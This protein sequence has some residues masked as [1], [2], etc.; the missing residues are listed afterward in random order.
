MANSSLHRNQAGTSF[1]ACIEA[2][3]A[4]EIVIVYNENT[5]LYITMSVALSLVT[6][7]GNLL[8]LV[9][10]QSVSSIHPPSKA[11]FQCL[12]ITDLGVGLICQPLFISYLWA[13]EERNWSFCR[14]MEGLAITAS[15]VFCGQ[16]I[17]TLTAL[18]VDRLLALQLRLR[19]RH[20]VTLSRVRIF[21]AAFWVTN[22]AFPFTFYGSK[23]FYFSWCFGWVFMCLTLSTCCY[24]KIYLVLGQRQP[25]IL[26][27]P[28]GFPLAQ[29]E[30]MRTRL[31]QMPD[32]SMHNF[33]SGEM[34][35]LNIVR[36]RKTVSTALWVHAVLAICYLPH[37]IATAVTAWRG[38]SMYISRNKLCGIITGMLLFFNSTLNPFLYC[39]KVKGI[40][41]AVK[42]TIGNVFRCS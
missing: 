4:R 20:V 14:T 42:Q 33:S 9:V 29:G 7:F 37:T 19:Y 34:P 25:K 40:R 3:S 28:L 31:A 11:L 35:Q 6:F 15:A 30:I 27:R 22:I 8:I 39:W 1:S 16:S 36:Y 38:E 17:T 12:S 21:L 10:L 5:N 13:I 26:P 23:P 18:S 32:H 24:V 41:Q 2:L